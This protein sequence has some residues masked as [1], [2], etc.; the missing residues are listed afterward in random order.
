MYNER[1]QGGASVLAHKV[2]TISASAEQVPHGLLLSYGSD[3][4]DYLRR[5]VGYVDNILKG[6]KPGDLPIEQPTRFKLVIKAL[7]LSVPLLAAAD[8]VIE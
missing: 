7:G 2:P 5:A 4:P 1:S 6:T 8:E 3:F